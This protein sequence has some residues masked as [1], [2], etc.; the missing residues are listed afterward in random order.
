MGRFKDIDPQAMETHALGGGSTFKFSAAKIS[1]L[2]ATEYTL[3]VIVVDCSGSV[4]PYT[5]Q[6]NGA[7][8]EVVRACRRNPRADNMMLRV[9]LFDDQVREFHGFKPLP[10][11]NEADYDS[12]VFAGGS[13]ALRDATFN[14]VR[15]AVVYGKQLVANQFSVNAAVF[16]LTDGA[17][18]ESKVSNAMVLQALQEAKTSEALESIMPVLIGVG[19]GSDP[20]QGLDAYL[21][22][23]KNEAGFQQYVGIANATEK[24]LAKLGGFISRSLSSQSQALG[25]GGASQSLSF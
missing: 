12:A 10:D 21:T 18:N 3:G 16:V 20:N 17:D 11:C 9:V 24:E 15:S 2:G 22:A 5:S 23:F 25:T 13:T 1:N 14:G 19:V 6:I 7:L 4:S 8:K